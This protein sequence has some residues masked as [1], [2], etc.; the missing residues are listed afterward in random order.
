MDLYSRIRK[1][2]ERS[3]YN[4]ADVARILDVTGSSCFGWELHPSQDGATR[5]SVE[6]LLKLAVIF[7]VR[8]EWLATGRGEMCF[9]SHPQI[10]MQIPKARPK[11]TEESLDTENELPPLL[12]REI[13]LQQRLLEGYRALSTD[14][15]RALLRLFVIAE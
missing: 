6:N 5:P 1:A 9:P 11:P 14:K 7:D 3:G 8:L 10:R 13:V 2:R 12:S 4:K 15:R